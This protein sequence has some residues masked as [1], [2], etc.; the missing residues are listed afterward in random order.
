MTA[1]SPA[2]SVCPKECVPKLCTDDAT[3]SGATLHLTYFC[4]QSST[5]GG[6][7]FITVTKT[8]T[9]TPTVTTVI[10]TIAGPGGSSTAPS[11]PGDSK[12]TSAP[13][14]VSKSTSA[15]TIVSKKKDDDEEWTTTTIRSTITITKT[16]YSKSRSSTDASTTPSQSDNTSKQSTTSL[17]QP[18][19]PLTNSTTTPPPTSAFPSLTLT[20]DHNTTSGIFYSAPPF[21]NSTTVSVL[22]TGHVYGHVKL[23]ARAPTPY[24]AAHEAHAKHPGV[25]F[26]PF[27]QAVHIDSTTYMSLDARRETTH[28][29]YP[30]AVTQSMGKGGAA[31][32]QAAR[33]GGLA[34]F[35]SVMAAVL[36]V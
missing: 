21:L 19:T 1:L 4:P 20:R 3:I 25:G 13:A 31:G 24:E 32:G 34:L 18:S 7:V 30:G 29:G 5:A 26:S 22:P 15:P 35:L 27:V 6:T 36:M 16:L 10:T 33:G 2:S 9:F 8:E 28:A 14:T 11:Q 17:A 23:P 12:S